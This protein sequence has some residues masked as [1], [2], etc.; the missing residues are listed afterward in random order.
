MK[1]LKSCLSVN[2]KVPS[3]SHRTETPFSKASPLL[4]PPLAFR[5]PEHCI[6]CSSVCKMIVL[7]NAWMLTKLREQRKQQ[8]GKPVEWSLNG[9]TWTPGH[10]CW[11][12]RF[13]KICLWPQWVMSPFY[14]ETTPPP[15]P[16]G[17]FCGCLLAV[18]LPWPCPRS[19]LQSHVQ[20]LETFLV[21]F[22]FGPD[23][24]VA[25]LVMT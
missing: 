6:A 2:M 12:S 5:I 19:F 8:E 24:V 4:S 10:L 7:E 18:L 13:S 20:H 11:W 25:H 22:H 14:T 3:L 15:T 23:L 9:G 17:Q 21:L 16:A 1:V